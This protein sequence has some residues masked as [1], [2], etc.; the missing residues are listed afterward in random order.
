MV[1]KSQVTPRLVESLRHEVI[2]DV[3][4][5]C[6]QTISI[7]KIKNINKESAQSFEGGRLYV[8]GPAT[9]LGKY[10]PKF[11]FYNCLD[12]IPITQVATGYLHQLALSVKGDVFSWGYNHAGC[13]LHEKDTYFLTEPT[14]VKNIFP[15]S[16]NLA[17]LKPCKQSS[18]YGGLDAGNAVDGNLDGCE[19]SLVHTQIDPQPYWECDLGNEF[20]VERIKLWNRTDTPSDKHVERD[21]FTRRL[22]PCWLII[23]RRPFSSQVGGNSLKSS[24]E[25]CTA[26]VRIV[27]NKRVTEWVLPAKSIGRYVRVQLESYSTLHFAQVQVFGFEKES[28]GKVH[29]ISAGKNVSSLIVKYSN[30]PK[31]DAYRMIS[32]AKSVDNFNCN[33]LRTFKYFTD[34]YYHIKK[35]AELRCAICADIDK[36]NC[37]VCALKSHYE[38]ELTEGFGEHFSERS[39]DEISSFLMDSSRSSIFKKEEDKKA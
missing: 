34:A 4:C 39:L 13:C 20:M 24:L 21:K 10:C 37:H 32:R 8:A 27:E 31:T 23:S 22:F 6:Y 9:V 2:V 25:I 18:V 16:K 3:S 17:L 28:F 33:I 5:G 19:H 26:K 1:G 29:K 38:R 11:Q 30:N 12:S 36:P 7:S 15:P 35:S 14:L